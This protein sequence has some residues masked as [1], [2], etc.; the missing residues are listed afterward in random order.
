MRQLYR[1]NVFVG[2]A[3]RDRSRIFLPVEVTLRVDCDKKRGAGE[4][5]HYFSWEEPP[6]ASK[7]ND[8][9]KAQSVNPVQ[10]AREWQASMD[11]RGES[12]A[13]LARRIG[14]SRARVSQ[15]LGILDLAPDV[16]ELLEQQ[17]EP[18]MA[19]ERTLRVTSSLPPERQWDELARLLSSSEDL[20][21]QPVAGSVPSRS[22]GANS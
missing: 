11:A 10:L 22:S 17:T 3:F 18:A 1:T 16:L 15:V 14:V 7:S 12:R 4:K 9:G 13:D 5:R 19:S 8:S 2:S 20:A 21:S 6:P